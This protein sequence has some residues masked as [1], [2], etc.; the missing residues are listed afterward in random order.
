MAQSKIGVGR[1]TG[2]A[3][4]AWELRDGVFHA[5][6][7]PNTTVTV[8]RYAQPWAPRGEWGYSWT[9]A[10]GRLLFDDPTGRGYVRLDVKG[11]RA[12]LDAATRAF[13]AD[14]IG[15]AG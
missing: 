2:S 13:F 1:Y 4:L 14:L 5:S 12:A 15:R 3:S 9:D 8:G 6:G 11:E 7:T 10:R